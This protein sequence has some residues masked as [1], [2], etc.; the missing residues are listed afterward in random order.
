MPGARA[1]RV[2]LVVDVADDLLDE[3]LQG[4]DPG[5]AAVLVDHD[6]ELQPLL[7]QQVQQGVESDQRL[8]HERGVHKMPATG[9]RA[10]IAPRAPRPCLMCTTP[11]TSSSDAPPSTGS[12]SAQ[13]PGRS[14]T[15]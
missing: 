4:D 14:T 8:R 7:A 6:R 3:V 2:V 13:S 10:S 11:T 9:V 12:G 1:E 5:R 15:S